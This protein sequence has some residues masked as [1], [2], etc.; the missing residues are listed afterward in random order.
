MPQ[1][2]VLSPV[3]HNGSNYKVGSV[4]DLEEA[5]AETLVSYG[6]I[7]LLPLE[8]VGSRKSEVLTTHELNINAA[9]EKEIAEA[10]KGVG[11][12]TA[13]AIVDKRKKLG[14]FTSI[15]Q[16]KEFEQVDWEALDSIIKF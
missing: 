7:A 11:P 9:T 10:I 16:L 6:A 15:D 2:S 1:Y 5:A 8:Q 4:I 13:K 14:K 12:A 3:R